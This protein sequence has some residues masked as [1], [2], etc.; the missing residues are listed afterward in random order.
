MNVKTLENIVYISMEFGK[1]S[2]KGKLKLPDDYSAVEFLMDNIEDW[3][4][5]FEQQF[6]EESEYLCEIEVFAQKKF[7]ELGWLPKM[8]TK[9]CYLYRDG[10]NYKVQNTCV[11]NGCLSFEE[12]RKIHDS[13]DCGEYFIPSEVGLPEERFAEYTEDDH[14][15]FELQSFED[16]ELPAQVSITPEELVKKFEACKNKWDDL[17]VV[18][19][20]LI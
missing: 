12:M 3:S 1:W 15:F 11:I 8:N 20:S 4:K 10:S 9:I 13:C 5:E 6:S 14:P 17:G 18:F 2:E 7:L 16:T 19:E